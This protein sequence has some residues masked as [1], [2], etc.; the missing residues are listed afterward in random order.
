MVAPTLDWLEGFEH[1]ADTTGISS[2]TGIWAALTRAGGTSY[3]A[4]RLGGAAIRLVE[5]GTTATNVRQDIPNSAMRVL[6][7]WFKLPSGAPSVDRSDIITVHNAGGTKVAGV[8]IRTSGNGSFIEAEAATGTRQQGPAI[9]DT[10]WHLLELKIDVSGTTWKVDWRVDRVAQTQATQ[11]SHTA[12]VSAT[13]RFGSNTA[14]HTAT[15]AWDDVIGSVTGTDYDNSTYWPSSSGDLLSKGWIIAISTPSGEGTDVL[16]TTNQVRNAAG[17]TSNLYQ[18]VDD[19]VNGAAAADTTTYVTYAST[20]QGDAASNYAEVALTDLP[21][22]VAAVWAVVGN[23]AMTAAGNNADAMIVRVVDSAGTTLSD[24]VNGDVSNASNLEYYRTNALVTVPAN[25]WLTD[26]NGCKIRIGLSSDTNPLPR[27][28]AVGLQFVYPVIQRT[29]AQ[30]ADAV[31]QKTAT[32]THST[33]AITQRTGTLTQQADALLKATLTRTQAADAVVK[34]TLTVTQAA[35]AIIERTASLSQLADAEVLAREAVAHAT[36]AVLLVTEAATQLV[37]AVAL[38]TGV[39]AQDA[40]AIVLVVGSA[41]QDADAVLVAGVTS[42]QQQ[43][44]AV[45][46]VTLVAT[47]DTDARIVSAT[48]TTRRVIVIIGG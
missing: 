44:D 19:W 40:D 38:A 41:T 33:D 27:A 9:T 36:D 21:S 2:G 37:D 43:A 46:L 29:V 32:K 15:V 20:T 8:S 42:V 30:S 12:D 23:A 35:D 6:A 26:F 47:H 13:I 22:G 48:P 16:G 11:G 1:R 4:G 24:I 14:A 17:T 28:S 45:L 39:V 18:E 3:I 34:K 25:G 31:I 5:D 10:G 7:G